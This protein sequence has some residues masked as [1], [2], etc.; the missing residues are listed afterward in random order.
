MSLMCCYGTGAEQHIVV[1]VTEQIRVPAPTAFKPECLK[2]V[3]TWN[4]VLIH[5]KPRF[6][7]TVG[8]GGGE[9]CFP[10]LKFTVALWEVYCLNEGW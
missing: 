4:M 8:N 5:T 6:G 10:H 3:F 9:V 7:G 1:L 2:M